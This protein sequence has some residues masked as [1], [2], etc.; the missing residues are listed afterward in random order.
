MKPPETVL[1]MG[2][3]E[4]L[5]PEARESPQAAAASEERC[6]FPLEQTGVGLWELDPATLRAWRSAQHAR[7][8][9]HD[10]TGGAWSFQDFLGSV[11]PE[12]RAQVESLVRAK[13]TARQGWSFECRIIRPDAGVIWIWVQAAFVP[14]G[15]VYGLVLDITQRKA[16]E[17][18]ARKQREFSQAVFDALE[19]HI[20]VLDAAGEI[21]AVNRSWRVFAEANQM[22]L[23]GAGLGGNYLAICD[24]AVGPEAA[25]AR[26]FAAGIRQVLE[27]AQESFARDY[28]CH[29]PV[30]KRWFHAKITRLPEAG[31]GRL[32]IAH[33]NITQVKQAEEQAQ[34]S[35]RQLRALGDN[36]P[37]AMVY[38]LV[39]GLQGPR[40]TFVSAGVERIHGVT[41]E[42]ALRDAAVV[43]GQVVEEDRARLAAQEEESWAS[44]KSLE[45][46]FR[47]RNARGELRWV[48]VSSQTG[49]LAD[50]SL[51]SDGVELDL[52]E[53]KQL[54]ASLCQTKKMEALG[55]LA[56]RMAHEF[57][58]LLA[59][60]MMN[61]GLATMNHHL[62][63]EVARLVDDNLESCHR[64]AGLIQLLLA[65]SRRS[66]LQLEVLDL[67]GLAGRQARLI[68]SILGKRIRVECQF[69]PGA[70]WVEADR[71]LMEQAVVNLC[72][73]ARDSMKEEGTLRLELRRVEISRHQAELPALARP[74]PY[75]C[76]AVGDTG[77]GMEARV[78]E[79][80][81]EPFFT[82]KEV[83]RG[84]GLGL[85]V[86]K[87]TVEQHRGWVEVESRV[88]QGSTFRIYLPAVAPPVPAP[89]ARGRR[90][91]LLAQGQGC[92][93][94]MEEKAEIRLVARR[95]LQDSGYCV[96]E[97][98]TPAEAL[99]IWAG[100]AAEI[101][102]VLAD[103]VQP[104]KI[105]GIDLAELFLTEKSGLKIIL[106][107][108][109]DHERE[110]AGQ[111]LASHAIFLSKP[112]LPKTLAAALTMQL[113]RKRA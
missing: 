97:A 24:G 32:V 17:E 52:T 50:G 78:M 109:H 36:L 5:P 69:A 108:G 85:A 100:H 64:A 28:A 35:A 95:L 49:E 84:T 60:M 103:I 59:G 34:A 102:L 94:V 101:G 30:A 8:F 41:V 25:E 54:E 44:G 45:A 53:R 10:N 56:G 98:A 33:E 48:H 113:Q 40:F 27:G 99:E 76:L 23:P 111:R 74:D 6:R 15:R 21:V 11:H 57:N 72:L 4:R 63:P 107:S 20:C 87:G 7:L 88:G 2:Q 39:R 38:Q 77:C 55:H 80:L 26:A 68:E 29:S 37:L 86:V 61:L 58:N 14:E 92:L 70:H 104:G 75:V 105:S 3:G 81:F 93:V 13:L 31:A 89:T 65:A 71:S 18:E 82:T 67:A 12:D 16:A 66:L 110:A 112:C 91:Q 83:G 47:I 42:T 106:I 46:E 43:Y 73:N 90:E 22:R 9:G 51:C 96:W 1:E 79:R 19:A 62:E